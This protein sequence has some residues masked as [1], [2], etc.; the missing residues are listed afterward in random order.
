[1]LKRSP[2]LLA[3]LLLLSCTGQQPL[4]QAFLSPPDDAKPVMIWQW[5]DGLVTQEGITRDLE[6][7][8]KA[9]IGGVQQ[10]L[11]GS[12]TQILVKDTAN[13]IGTDNWRALMKHAIDECA[14]LGLT[15]GTHNCPGWSSS[16]F[17]TVRPELSMQKLVWTETPVRG[18]GAP[19]K[20]FL[21]RP[22]VDPKWDYYEDIAVLAG[23]PG[24][25]GV[26]EEV[27]VVPGG[28]DGTVEWTAPRGAWILFR[29]GHTTNGKTNYAT[30]PEGGVG[31]ECDKMDP[32]AV[33]AF[34][35]LYPRQIIEI[36]GE[37][38]GRTFTRF[39]VDSYE[40][41]GQEWTRRFPQ[42]FSRRKGY[43]ILPWL[44]ALTGRTVR[45]REETDKVMQ[46]WKDTVREL[47]AEYYYG[48]LSELAHAHG[49]ELLVEPYGTGS[50][51]PFNPIDTDRVIS[52][53]DP[54]DPVAAEFWTQPLTWGWPE[55]PMVVAAARHGG[56]QTV[57]AE[58]FTCIPGFAWRD[59]PSGLKAVGDKAFCLG[60]NAFMFHAGAQNPWTGAT[61]GMT[62]GM[63]GTQWTPGQTWW[64]DGAAPLFD[65]FTRCQALLR[66]GQF[67]D[68]YTTENPSLQASD[69]RVQWIHR[70]D[71]DGTEY[72]FVTNT[73]DEAVSATLSIALQGRVPEIWDPRTLEMRDAASWALRDGRTL[74]LERLEPRA[75]CFLVFRRE[76]KDA[77]PGLVDRT[78]RF[79]RV[80]APG[81]AWTLIFP[82][83]WDAPASVTL[84]RLVSWTESEDPG[85]KYFS[86][87]ATYSNTFTLD[88]PD[89]QACYWLD[90]GMVRNLAVVRV[91]GRDAGTLWTPPFRADITDLI[92][93]GENTLE[94][95]VS[96]LWV[97]R[98]IGDEQEP[99]DIVW[100]E[101]GRGGRG[102]QMREVPEWL[103]KGWPR[104][105]SGRKTV[106][107]YKSFTQDDP[108]VESGL[109]GPVEILRTGR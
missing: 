107:I 29:F 78:P 67:V 40:A 66:R 87:T 106:V 42:E 60:I 101:P 99:D 64:K 91:N 92:R 16:A 28:A 34:W 18:T 69:K 80:T 55:V 25:D 10:F 86:G 81:G 85:M 61:P 57:W 30:A 103:Q 2:F 71:T 15:F 7:Y 73:A 11:V 52:R 97:N 50:A 89:R 95:D 72:W 47:F 93:P 19:V 74:I 39:E 94:I 6:A 75:S 54:S 68:D 70:T 90:L 77:G 23:R 49:L 96:N 108:L 27:V 56:R 84:D 9:G 4:E 98:M 1:M 38:T 3:A 41:G 79:E 53:I 8:Q 82:E 76:A 65:Y 5:M 44:P 51:Q 109:L 31:L 45:S 102:Q 62:F 104:P 59:D 43:D 26:L 46:D 58:G 20:L 37:H 48:T 83:G 17:P 13:A 12:E 63:W 22:A 100:S 14:R 32:E 35:E 21:P 24:P 36:A 105:S 88:A 33:R